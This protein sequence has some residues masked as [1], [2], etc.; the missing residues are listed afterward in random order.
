MRKMIMASAIM[1]ACATPASVGNI[2]VPPPV[3]HEASPP[4]PPA[5]QPFIE[6]SNPGIPKVEAARLARLIEDVAT[7]K[8]I[9][10][11][12]MFAIVR[13]ESHFRTGLKACR[14]Y[15]NTRRCDYGIAQVNSFWIDEL[16]LDAN[17]LRHDDEYNLNIATDILKG[18]LDR[19][20][21]EGRFA[22]SYYNTSDP[23]LRVV[24]QTMIERHR[25]VA[26]ALRN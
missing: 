8:G 16:E 7:K 9:P 1:G 13:Q 14:M 12:L 24:Y 3:A 6:K 15:G 23:E 20:G 11:D 26:V 2:S 5:Y 10:P 21:K 17:R 4:P 22:Y 25:R 19:H 18:V